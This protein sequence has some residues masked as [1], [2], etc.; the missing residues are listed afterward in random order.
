ML[1]QIEKA[2]R[3]MWEGH[4]RVLEDVTHMLGGVGLGLLA[5]SALRKNARPVGY[6]LMGLSVLLHLYA[7]TTAHAGPGGT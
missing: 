7:L 3:Q 6:A 2:D 1:E 5:Y 4:S